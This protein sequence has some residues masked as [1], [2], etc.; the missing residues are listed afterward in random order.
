MKTTLP[1][2][3]TILLFTNSLFAQLNEII[4]QGVTR[5]FIVHLPAGY[6]ESN[7]YP[8]VLNLHGLNASA[9]TQQNY[10]KFDAVADAEGFIVVYPNGIDKSWSTIGDSD[11]DFLTNL[12][13]HIRTTY[14]CSNDLFVTGMS[15]GGFMTYKF[16]N[17]TT[18]NVTAIAVGSGNMSNAFQNASASAPQIPVMHFHGTED[19]LVSYNGTILISTVE[20]TVQWWVNHN[21]CTTNPTIT[22]IPDT[23][24]EDNSTVEKYYYGDGAN[25]SEV[26]FYKIVN[27]GHTW[28]GASPIPA[29]GNTNKDIDQSAIIGSFFKEFS[30]TDTTGIEDTNNNSFRVY[31]NPFVDQFTVT[32]LNNDRMTIIVY[33]LLSQQIIKENFYNTT[34]IST[35]Q[36]PGGIYFYELRDSNQQI[37]SGKIIKK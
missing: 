30:S 24:I 27:G 7:E 25:G 37:A 3:S 28:S 23:N 36:L 5:T 4:D 10:S 1:L 9:E 34:S 35:E 8:L 11:S 26:T 29:F 22:T 17:T 20:D 19:N 6:S 16:A 31:P 21:N 12:V 18:H 2:L 13:N 15:Q 32:T 14:S 33:D